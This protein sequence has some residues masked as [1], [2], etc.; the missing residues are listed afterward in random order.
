MPPKQVQLQESIESQDQWDKFLDKDGLLV[1]DVYSKWCGPCKAVTGLLRRIK[2]ELG[3]DLLKFATAVSDTIDSLE[4]YRDKSQPT[5][6]FYGGHEL[7]GVVRGANGPLIQKSIKELLEQEHKI[8]DGHMERPEF[9]DEMLKSAV[10][11]DLV[12]EEEEKESSPQVASKRK[13]VT[14]AIIKPDAVAK[15]LV[16][17]ILEKVKSRGLEVLAHEER[18]LTREEAAEF[19]SHHSESETFEELLDYMSSGPCHVLVLTKGVTGEDAVPEL[20]SL[21]G[22]TD[23]EKAK[24]EAPDTLRAMY[25]TNHIQ[26]AIHACD[27]GESA[28]RELAFFFPDFGA[29]WVAGREP[30]IQK[31]FALL[32]PDAARDHKD[33][34]LAKVKEAGFTIALEKE[35]QLTDEQIAEFYGHHTDK[36]WFGDFTDHMKS[37]PVLALALAREEAVEKWRALIGPK[38]IQQA[39]EEAPESLRAEFSTENSPFN[40]LHGADNLDNAEHELNYFFP[41]EKT[42]AVV[43]PSAFD[44]KDNIVEKIKEAGFDV[45][46]QKDHHLTK[47]LAQQLYHEHEGKEFYEGLTDYMSSGPSHFMVLS[48]HDAIAGLRAVMGPTD[49]DEAREKYPDSLRALF[50]EDK[51]KNSIHGSSNPDHAERII[52]TFFGDSELEFDAAQAAVVEDAVAQPETTATTAEE[53]TEEE[54]VTAAA[55]EGGTGEST[56]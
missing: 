5:F 35:I 17:D 6:L 4:N 14:V 15:G 7:Q 38:D 18:V 34:I 44:A 27:S 46:L 51:M 45:V 56:E 28:A 13:D 39:K 22:P 55:D 24:E 26:N 32:R 49:P 9:I 37:G 40:A 21:V 16:D 31:T 36:D 20:R 43:K 50:G 52:K 30:K 8:Q 54:T 25:G 42:V 47:E 3:D 53:N 12:E 19:Y 11:E 41:V 48:R 23:S 2:N 10:I 29:P 33:E 1:V